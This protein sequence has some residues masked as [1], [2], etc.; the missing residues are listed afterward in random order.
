MPAVF[1]SSQVDELHSNDKEGLFWQSSF[2]N[3][4]GVH[5]L[6]PPYDELPFPLCKDWDNQALSTTVPIG[7]HPMIDEFQLENTH[8]VKMNARFCK[9]KN[10]NKTSF[11]ILT[12]VLHFLQDF[13]QV[14]LY[15][16]KF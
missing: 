4:P 10:A 6:Y 8:F 15:Q 11:T 7:A 5:N 13:V 1:D 12:W 16:A 3:R 2:V 9:C 14:V